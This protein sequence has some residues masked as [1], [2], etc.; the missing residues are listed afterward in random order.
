MATAS[1]GGTIFI[2]TPNKWRLKT[3][4]LS[5]VCQLG[6]FVKAALRIVRIAGEFL[7]SCSFA[8]CALLLRVPPGLVDLQIDTGTPYKCLFFAH[9]ESLSSLSRHGLP[10]M[11][12]KHMSLFRVF[13][14]N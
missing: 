12:A 3:V 13:C 7:G 10:A 6:A 1:L 8:R 14:E 5:A 4:A 9:C 2:T 11:I